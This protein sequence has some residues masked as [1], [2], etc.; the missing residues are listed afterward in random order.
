[1]A[2]ESRLRRRTLA[3]SSLVG[4]GA[5]LAGLGVAWMRL[6][7]NDP[8]P[9]GAEQAFWSLALKNL[10]G[11]EAA[12]AGYKGRPLLVNFWATWCP[13][14]VEELPLLDAFFQENKSK[15]WQVLGIAVDRQDAVERFLTQMPI[16]FP[17]LMAGPSGIAL[18]QSLGN[19][20]GG[21]PFS[22]LFGADGR[23]LRHRI[24]KLSPSDLLEWKG[25]TA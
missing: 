3:L 6:G 17:M 12:L 7:D 24:G 25:L 16:A 4:L 10:D 23:V 1:M 15:S 9:D 21:L 18:T 2:R 5:A 14:C 8:L 13:P 20:Q 22:V 19:R 11:S